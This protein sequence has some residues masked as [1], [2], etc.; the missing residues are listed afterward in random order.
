MNSGHADWV[1]KWVFILNERNFA[2]TSP[3]AEKR[4]ML[5]LLSHFAPLLLFLY[6]DEH[7]YLFNAEDKSEFFSKFTL[8]MLFMYRATIAWKNNTHETLIQKVGY[9]FMTISQNN[10]IYCLHPWNKFEC[11]LRVIIHILQRE[12]R[13]M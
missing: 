9:F 2:K 4:G 6:T 13:L 11:G 8:K 12:T 3:A 5:L 7:E 10:L 1:H